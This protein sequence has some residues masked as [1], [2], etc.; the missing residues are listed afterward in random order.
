MFTQRMMKAGEVLGIKLL[1]H[2][3]VSEINWLSIK[4]WA[5]SRRKE[6]GQQ[7]NL[8]PM[9]RTIKRENLSNLLQKL[10]PVF[11]WRDIDCLMLCF[12]TSFWKVGIV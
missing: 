7:N 6:E 4:K 9:S 1:D 5:Y 8:D 3:I 11:P 2:S 12:F 10:I